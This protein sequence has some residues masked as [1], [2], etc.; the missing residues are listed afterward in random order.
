MSDLL[1]I[2]TDVLVDIARGIETMFKVLEDLRETFWKKE[3]VSQT[4]Q[5]AVWLCNTRR[6]HISLGYQIP[7]KIHRKAA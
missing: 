6:P 7:E 3:Q 4:L 1:L 5:Q 2:E